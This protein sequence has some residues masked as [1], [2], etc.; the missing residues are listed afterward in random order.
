MTNAGFTTTEVEIVQVEPLVAAVVRKTV[1]L[2]DVPRAQRAARQVLDATL[3]AAD[4]QPLGQALTVWRPPQGGAIDYAPGVLV[5]ERVSETGEIS[6]FTLPEGRA[7]HLRLT[8][9]YEALP[10]AWGRLFAACKAQTL[11]GLNW[12]IYGD[13]E[14]R[15]EDMRTDLYALLA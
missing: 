11:A 6:M 4:I 3:K 2:T 9:P 15:P 7:A 10:D 1:P 13:P 5:P 14:A 8:G 12:E